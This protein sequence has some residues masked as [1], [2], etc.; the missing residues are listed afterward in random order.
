MIRG[1]DWS[2][3]GMIGPTAIFEFSDHT[4]IFPSGYDPGYDWSDGDFRIL[5]SDFR[6]IPL[7]YP[8]GMI[9]GYDL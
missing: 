4:L 5:F 6:I 3:E 2:Y 9:P 7:S 1:Y 8:Q